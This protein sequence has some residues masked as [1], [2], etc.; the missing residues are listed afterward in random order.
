MSRFSSAEVSLDAAETRVQ[1]QEVPGP[2]GLAE[3]GTENAP[4]WELIGAGRYMPRRIRGSF[5]GREL[6]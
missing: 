1:L 3:A 2:G 5:R 4:A 6:G